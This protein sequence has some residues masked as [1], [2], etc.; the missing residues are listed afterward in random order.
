MPPASD[1]DKPPFVL[2]YAP[3]A[4]AARSVDVAEGPIASAL[5]T[6][7]PMPFESGVQ[8]AAA[9]VDFNKPARV[10]AYSVEGAVGSLTSVWTVRPTSS[11]SDHVAPSSILLN[12]PCAPPA[13]SA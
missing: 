1:Q 10:P 13:N 6:G 12:T 11:V 7:V 9:A 2:R 8:D 4:V 5:T 3:A